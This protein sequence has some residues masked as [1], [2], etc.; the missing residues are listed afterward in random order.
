MVT[1]LLIGL[2]LV[3]V[4]LVVSAVLMPRYASVCFPNPP[5]LARVNAP[6]PDWDQYH[7]SMELPNGDLYIVPADSRGHFVV[8]KDWRV[9]CKFEAHWQVFTVPRGATTDFASI[10][11]VLQ[12][13]LSPLNN[14]VY[15]AILHD[16]LYRDPQGACSEN[17]GPPMT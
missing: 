6:E 13:L 16:Y 5:G 4:L 7:R 9:H 10:P 3:L 2:G 15:A 1:I 8:L 14:T 11:R 12:S 17:F